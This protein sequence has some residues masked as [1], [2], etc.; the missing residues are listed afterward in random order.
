MKR[1]TYGGEQ[2]LPRRALL[3]SLAAGVGLVAAG[4]PL[5]ADD[6][7]LAY[8]EASAGKTPFI[9]ARDGTRLFVSD[10]GT[11]RPLVFVAPWGLNSNWWEYQT[12]QLAQQNV[13][14]IAY[15][16]RGHGRSEQPG[17]GYDFDTLSDDL[18]ALITQRNLR[19]ATLVGHSMGCGEIVRYLARHGAGRVSRVVLVSTITPFIMKAPDNPEGVDKTL[20]EQGRVRLSKD[21]PHQ[22]AIAAAA[23]FGAPKNPVSAEVM[24]WWTRMMVDQCTLKTMLDLH[25]VFT[26]TDFRADLRKI[27]VPTLLIHGDS[28]TSSPVDFSARRTSPL[29]TGS[30]L[31]V[32]E[33][34]AHGLPFTH[35]DRL[36]ADL[37][38]FART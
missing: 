30:Q 16:R 33:G 15:D 20:L 18:D 24:D 25:R 5:R 26:E 21:R 2:R 11:G 37:L 10:W 29:I 1:C 28:D 9:E 17:V 13:R 12:T 6:A 22:I 7:A 23:F 27:T 34:A 8:R 14:C 35:M 38:A 19:D 36:N 32:Y 3:Q 31:K 4:A